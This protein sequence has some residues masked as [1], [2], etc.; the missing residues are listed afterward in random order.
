MAR[1]HARQDADG[2]LPDH[3]ATLYR[4]WFG[5]A[6]VAPIVAAGVLRFAPLSAPMKVAV[7]AAFAGA[8]VKSL[9]KLSQERRRAA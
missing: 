7:A 6:L 3:F 2:R 9:A 8:V 5:L 4:L 1:F